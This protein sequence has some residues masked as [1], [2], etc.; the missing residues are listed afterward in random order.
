MRHPR[1]SEAWETFDSLHDWF[2]KD[3][4]N[5]RLGLGSDGFNPFGAMRTNY[6]VWPVVLIPYNRLPWEC[7]K[8]TSL[9]LSMIIPGAKMPGNN[10]DVY[11]QPLIEELKELWHDRVQTLNRFKNEMF[12][13]RAALMWTISDFSGLGTLIGWDVHSKCACPTCNFN[14]DSCRLKHGGKWCF[15]GGHRFSERGHKFRLSRAKFNGKVELRDPPTILTWSEILEQLGGINVSFGKELQSS[16]GKRPRGKNV[17]E[18][19]ES[20]MWR[21]K[22]IFFDLPY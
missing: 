1:D 9:I 19:D 18:D 3:P 10:I 8:P 17:E 6:S 14:T 7:M 22:C 15:M 13:L 11:L 2:V 20:G 12:T 4:R 5:V 21:K 16:K